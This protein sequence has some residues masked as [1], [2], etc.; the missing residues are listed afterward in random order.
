MDIL[1]ILLQIYREYTLYNQINSINSLIIIYRL[2]TII[3]QF[4][5]QIATIQS[6]AKNIHIS[7]YTEIHLIRKFQFLLLIYIETSRAI[8]FFIFVDR[9]RSKTNRSEIFSIFD[10]I[11]TG[12]IFHDET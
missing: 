1:Q 4:N 10:I 8:L 11:S 5:N 12:Y 9:N 3:F 7:R 6:I 2:M